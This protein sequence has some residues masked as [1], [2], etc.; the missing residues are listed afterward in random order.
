MPKTS[1][2]TKKAVK[3]IKQMRTAPV[4]EVVAVSKKKSGPILLVKLLLVIAIGVVVFLLAQKYKNIFIAGTV[5][6]SV[7]TRWELN[8]RMASQYGSQTFEEIV[9]ERLLNE[10]LQK[11]KIV[12]TDKEITD[13]L[14]KIK[15]QYGGDSQYNAAIAQFGMTQAQALDSIKQSIGL[16]KLIE[17]T[18][19]IT[20]ADADIAKYFND[21]KATYTGKTLQDVSAAIK[22][23]LYQQA[24][25]SKSQAWYTQIRKDASVVSFL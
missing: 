4:E 10:N 12:V 16:K 9:S 14:A 21:N 24:V 7:I 11:N 5:N 22:D 1:T 6:K 2:K 25:Y 8:Q 20:V 18:N 23:I 13:E 17:A 19:T 3:V 15:A